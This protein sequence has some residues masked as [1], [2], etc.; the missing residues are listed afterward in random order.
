MFENNQNCRLIQPQAAYVHFPFC[1]S[2]CNYCDFNSYTGLEHLYQQYIEALIKEIEFQK[3]Y[4]NQPLKS[5]YFGGGTPSIIQS[6]LLLSILF[7]I[8]NKFGV[9]NTTEITIEANPKTVDINSLKE[10]RNGFNRI[11]IGIQSFDDKTLEFLGRPHNSQSAKSAFDDARKA[12]FENISV[13]LIYAV[14]EQNIS[15]LKYD[16][17]SAI[18]LNPEHISIY[19]LSIEENTPIFDMLKRND[20]KIPDEDIQ[21]EMYDFIISFLTAKSYGH[22]EVSNFS[23]PTKKAIHNQAY[24]NN[25]QYYGFG[26]GA[27]SYLGHNRAKRE[28]SPQSYIYKI[29]S[30][31]S[32]IIE[33]EVLTPSQRI[34]ESIMLGLRMIDG[35]DINKFNLM[36]DIDLLSHYEFVISNL[37]DRKLITISNG[38]IKTTHKGLL[39]L[40]EVAGEFINY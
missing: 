11:S 4:N 14:P 20:I 13:D 22:Y 21:I 18:A 2:K 3:V 35:I 36:H 19:E 39:M 23:K 10:L 24:W 37:I 26:A 16:L 15:K 29:M 38:R 8:Q 34:A 9:D 31:K 32:A 33:S 30:N 40:N 17:E 6:D 27:V 12:G 28:L 5:I 1:Y 25:F 7:S